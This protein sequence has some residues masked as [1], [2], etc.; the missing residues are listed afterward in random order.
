VEIAVELGRLAARIKIAEDTTLGARPVTP[1]PP[2]PSGSMNFSL[3]LPAAAP[4]PAA[5]AGGGL[6]G[7]L[8][9]A[10]KALG[11]YFRNPANMAQVLGASGDLGR[12]LLGATGAP[13]LFA[14]SNL[15]RGFGEMGSILKGG[16]P[17]GNP[18]QG[19]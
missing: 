3:S 12:G 4:R 16:I 1:T 18:G 15:P 10:G 17:T 8:G 11:Q 9:G 14:L 6:G 13:G 19:I 5:P 7:M 2:Q